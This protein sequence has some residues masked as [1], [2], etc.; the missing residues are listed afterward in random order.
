MREAL[1]Y[2]GL[3]D[4]KVE[5]QLCAHGCILAPGE[6]SRC[7]V[8]LN[9]GGTLYAL[10]YERAAAVNVD[11][12]EKKPLFH[13]LPGSISLSI[14]TVGCNFRCD[15][16][17]N[18][19]MSR[20]AEDQDP[21]QQRA[22]ELSPAGI[23]EHCAQREIPSI[24]YTYNEPTVF[25][26][27]AL[28]TAQLA[29]ERGMKN[30]FVSNGFQSEQ[31]VELLAPYLDGINIDLKSFSDEFY[32]E[33]CQARLKPVL[34]TIERMHGHGIWVEV[35]TLVIPGL[36]DSDEELKDVAEFLVGVDADIPWHLTAFHPDY[37]LTSRPHTA[38][39]V[40]NRDAASR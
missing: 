35:T 28:E 26:E 38:L 7:G 1:L 10:V 19:Q 37:L 36:N 6:R 18:W 40:P 22:M 25:F 20:G 4:G 31:A 27:Y 2:R 3:D 5:C 16:C 30:T 23:V 21:R 15:F 17:Q 29:H 14:G 39:T 11:P 34:E 32:R 8:R 13:F 9:E 24:S 12:I 33:R